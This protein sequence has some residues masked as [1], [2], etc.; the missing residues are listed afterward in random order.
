[1]SGKEESKELGMTFAAEVQESVRRRNRHLYPVHCPQSDEH[2]D[3]HWTLLS[4][5]REDDESPLD[6]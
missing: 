2:L 1:M 3:G 6:V 5:E 4:L